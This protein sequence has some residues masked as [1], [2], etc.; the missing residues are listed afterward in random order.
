MDPTN[1]VILLLHPIAALIV[2]GWMIRQ[3]RWRQRGRILKGDERKVAVESHQRDGERLYILAWLLVLGG[4]IAHATYRIRT[5]S[6]T[7]PEALLPSGAGG[8]HAGG[9]LLGLALLTV[10][11][12]K[13]RKT[14]ICRSAGFPQCASVGR[15]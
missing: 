4:F 13:G 11:W 1:L 9:G 12:R 2:I 6:V 8:L 5:E 7:L 3:H 15:A 10:L 14:A